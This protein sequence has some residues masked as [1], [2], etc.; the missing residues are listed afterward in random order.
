MKL[1]EAAKIKGS[2]WQSPNQPWFT[3]KQNFRRPWFLLL[4]L[5]CVPKIGNLR[6]HTE[7]F[8]GSESMAPGVVDA[9]KR[10]PH[11]PT[12]DTNTGPVVSFS[13]SSIAAHWND[14]AYRSILELAEACDVPVRWS[15]RTGVCHNCESGLI[16]GAVVYK[17]E[18]LDNPA[19]GNLLICCSQPLRDVVIDL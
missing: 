6:V 18:P 9:P 17:P 13:R 12:D 15:C 4:K 1:A 7:I 8:N 11:P 2:A 10:S 5:Y 19:D 3:R 16:S 14:S